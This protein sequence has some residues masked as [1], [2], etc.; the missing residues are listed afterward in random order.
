MNVLGIINFEDDS[1][2]I[3]GLGDYRPVPAISFMGRYRIID[4][5][6]SNMTNSGI[7]NL[8]VFAKEKPR[9]LYAHLSDGTMY[10]INSKRGSLRILYGE[11]PFSSPIYNTDVANFNLNLQYIEEDTNPYVLI[12]P[13]K[14]IYNFDFNDALKQH[15]E[16]KADITVLYTSTNEAKDRFLS[17][18][19]IQLDKEKRITSF[20]K[21]RGKN[22][23]KQVSMEAYIL[24]KALF[25]QLIKQAGDISS[26]Y[27]FKDI[28]HDQV[29][30]LVI[31]GYGVRGYVACIDSLREYYRVS[32]ELKNP[33]SAEQV[34]KED[35]P[36]YTQ[37]VNSSPT[38]YTS[39]ADVKDS[40]LAN[41]SLIEGT[42][43]GSILGRNVTIKQ[44]AV[45]KN[46][47]ILT[48]AV[49]DKDAKLDYVIVDKYAIVHH[50]KKLEGT[51]EAPV[52]VKRRDRI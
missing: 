27:W 31:K 43:E 17:C 47:I 14:F 42:V 44:G 25:I 32:M 15:I 40:V 33:N 5:I 36:I 6:L 16:S 18:D 3:D 22:K 48:D 35:R 1:A 50:I 30:D 38:L 2:K 28:L 34:F 9:N 51:E 39:D 8:L 29:N 19:V 20:E 23:S 49:I 21:N 26:L 46:S 10:N 11:K 24:S 45:V 37:T 13:S 7:D 12:A 41:G 52:Y 4:V